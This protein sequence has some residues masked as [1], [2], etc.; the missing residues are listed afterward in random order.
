MTRVYYKEA[1]GA[2]VVFDVTR[3]TSDTISSWKN[4]IDQKI[5]LPDGRPLPTILV[6]NKCDLEKSKSYP[7]SMDEFCQKKGFIGWFE[8]SAKEDINVEKAFLFLL[9][10]IIEAKKQKPIEVENKPQQNVSLK[11]S[12]PEP[13]S[14]DCC[15]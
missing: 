9:D 5:T 6:A 14:S 13:K 11:T 12:K 4:D 10:K 15:S 2:V 3:F 8:T 1:L 7:T